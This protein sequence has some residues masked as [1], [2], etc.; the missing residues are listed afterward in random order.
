MREVSN[1]AGSCVANTGQIILT[2]K[3]LDFNYCRDKVGSQAN[4]FTVDRL[5]NLGS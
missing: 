3:Q 4:N 1:D 5:M 2:N